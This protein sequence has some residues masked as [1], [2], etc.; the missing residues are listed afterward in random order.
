M[1]L[2]V[3]PYPHPVVP[4]RA[5]RPEIEDDETALADARSR[6]DGGLERRRRR[7]TAPATPESAPGGGP[8][9]WGI[10]PD[11]VIIDGGKGQLSAAVEMMDALEL[12]EIPIVGLAKEREE[13][14]LKHARTR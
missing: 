14:F 4:Q 12:S 11:L 2:E 8:G 3:E 5:D 13:M 9:G 1:D 7:R 10:F 6:L